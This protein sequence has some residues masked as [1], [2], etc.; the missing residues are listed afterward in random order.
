MADVAITYWS[1]FAKTGAPGSV[2]GVEWPTFTPDD[3]FQQFGPVRP[4]AVAGCRHEQ[5]EAL[6]DLPPIIAR[7]RDVTG[8]A[9]AGCKLAP[10]TQVLTVHPIPA[11]GDLAWNRGQ[12][13]RHP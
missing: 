2:A 9:N 12:Q 13:E 8:R 6:V 4:Q 7:A 10:A 1:N 11:D 3:T 5:L